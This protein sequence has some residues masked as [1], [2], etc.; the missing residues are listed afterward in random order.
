[1]SSG[2]GLAKAKKRLAKMGASAE[3][4]A[5]FTGIKSDARA[6]AQEFGTSKISA[7]PYLRPA[8][9]SNAQAVVSRLGEALAQQL[10]KYRKNTR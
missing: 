8:M 9:E 5:G 2:R 4:V 1:M 6:I 10:N 3:Q 7:Q